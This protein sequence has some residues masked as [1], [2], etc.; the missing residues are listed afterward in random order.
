MPD[1]DD[2]DDDLDASSFEL[3]PE[4]AD[5]EPENHPDSEQ[6]ETSMMHTD[7]VWT[8]HNETDDVINKN[9]STSSSSTTDTDVIQLDN[10]VRMNEPAEQQENEQGTRFRRRVR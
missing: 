4:Y 5:V 3:V 8:E 6:P 9:I 7:N 2:S 1:I 10:Q